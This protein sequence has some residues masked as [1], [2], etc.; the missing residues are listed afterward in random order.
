M[1]NEV[2][3]MSQTQENNSELEPVT[4]SAIAV[5]QP[6]E[7]IVSPVVDA[8]QT[9]E[10]IAII[11]EEP[12]AE[13]VP[14]NP[15]EAVE[16]EES[17]ANDA[18]E[19]VIS[20]SPALAEIV[21]DVNELP[22]NET[23]EVIATNHEDKLPPLV[24]PAS[25]GSEPA[26]IAETEAQKEAKRVSKREYFEKVFNEIK[27]FKENNQPIEVEVK[28]RI[29]GGLR[30]TY[31][32]MPMFLPTSHYSL[33]RNPSEEEMIA[34]VGQKFEVLIHEYQ[35]Y[36]EGR[37][38]IIVSR[39]P[40]LLGGAWEKINAGDVI[41]GRVSSVASFGV[42]VEFGG[43]EGL[44][45]ISRLS[46]IHIDDPSRFFK[47][48][49]VIQA[50]I[51]EIDK[52]KN[53]I[54]LSRKEL[55]ESPWK[56]V[57]ELFPAGSRHKGLVRRLTDFGAYIELKPGVDGL[58]R[59]AE[60]SWTKRIKKPSDLLKPGQEVE[61]E[62]ISVSE[63]KQTASLSYKNTLPNPLPTLA[64]RF[65]VDS[66]Y[67]GEIIQV[68]PQGVIISISEELD[69][70]MPRSKMKN[71][72]KGK[73]IPFAVGEKIEVLIAD[74]NPAEESLIL[75][76]KY[77]DVVDSQKESGEDDRKSSA[78]QADPKAKSSLSLG[79]LLSEQQRESLFNSIS[80]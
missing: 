75:S 65:P 63:E 77:E 26:H 8:N 3:N 67:M 40:M 79:D 32:D 39:K 16:I 28:S 44:I 38:A 55:E 72:L 46:K 10:P 4:T 25:D 76:P 73:K 30:V 27:E 59:T 48:G 19:V 15:T 42:F 74:I 49:D 57:D 36:D 7:Q 61:V 68:I 45:H 31:K 20:E 54:A 78:K 29:R 43:L 50:A 56:G 80:K 11:A 14:Q 60:L 12:K 70:F 41:E 34:A 52:A 21:A 37:K 66:E 5:E 9:I 22:A 6:S 1:E 35:E 23:A 69:G 18:I 13:E 51:I 58:L 62:I 53:R 64:E 47:K 71:L 24:I 33:K 2:T 17:P